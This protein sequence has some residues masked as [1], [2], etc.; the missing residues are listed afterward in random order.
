MA[1][2]DTY[3]EEASR[4]G[5]H[6]F[7]QALVRWLCIAVSLAFL[8]AVL[9]APLA[10][11]FVMAFS[12]GAGQG[13]AHGRSGGRTRLIAISPHLPAGPRPWQ[14]RARVRKKVLPRRS[15]RAAPPRP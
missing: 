6:T 13:H 7:V 1:A 14:G 12:R 5:Q 11:V 15:C 4:P 3:A 10:T 8:A 2:I 9:L